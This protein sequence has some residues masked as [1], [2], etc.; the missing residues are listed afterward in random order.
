MTKLEVIATS[1]PDAVAA[2]QGGA[3][4]VEVCIDLPADGLTPPLDMVKAMRDAVQIDMNVM[5]RPHNNGFVYSEQEIDLM[6]TQIEHFKPL[7]IQTLVFGAHNPDG[8]LNSA[9]IRRIAE[10]AS[11]VPLTLHRALDRCGNPDAA[12]RD[13]VGVV[14]RVLTSGPAP[15]AS[16]GQ[17]GLRRWVSQFGEVY[18]FAVGGGIRMDN[19]REIVTF[20]SVHEC[21]VGTAA[22]TNDAVNPDKV[23]ELRAILHSL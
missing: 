21:H 11:P 4:S 8:T 2:A 7:G 9:L 3:D 13:L 15:S 14:Q 10:A 1:L 6:L 5:L 17:D 22:R 23:R 20:T 18:R 16:E 19:A 12:L